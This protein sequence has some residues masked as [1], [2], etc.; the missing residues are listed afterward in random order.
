MDATV[1]KLLESPRLVLYLRQLE[2]VVSREREAREH[3]Y[4]ETID[5]SGLEF[6]NG[7]VTLQPRSSLAHMGVVSNLLILLDTFVNLQ[8]LGYAATSTLIQLTRNDYEPDLC[9]FN[10]EKS[11]SFT[12]EQMIFPV[13]DLVVEVLSESTAH[14]DRGIKFSDYAAHGIAEYWLIDPVAEVLEQYLLESE[15]YRLELKSGTGTVTSSAVEGFELPIRAL[16]DSAENRR[17]L[18]AILTDT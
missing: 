1:E 2:A 7:S 5:L 18:K 15:T 16:F 14:R 6:I 11:A 3:F 17:V 9:F 4:R 10:R 8:A 13:P 12:P